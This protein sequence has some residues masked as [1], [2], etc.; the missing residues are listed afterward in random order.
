MDFIPVV[1]GPLWFAT[2]ILEAGS[3]VQDAAE[4]IGYIK[5]GKILEPQ[6]LYS[7]GRMV[8]DIF[9]LAPEAGTVWN[10]VDG[11]VELT[12]NGFEGVDIYVC[13]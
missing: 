13:D 4:M 12:V 2:E 5:E 7:A 6:T 10:I 1:G 3:A 8:M 11:M 9:S